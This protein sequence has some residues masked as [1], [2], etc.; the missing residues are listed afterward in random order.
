[1]I[2]VVLVEM[3]SFREVITVALGLWACGPVEQA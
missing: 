2:T 1:M 3:V